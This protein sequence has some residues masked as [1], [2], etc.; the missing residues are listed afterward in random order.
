VASSSRPGLGTET[1]QQL[2]ALQRQVGERSTPLRVR[3]RQRSRQH[4]RRLML[5][6]VAVLVPLVLAL[7]LALDT[8][9]GRSWLGDRWGDLSRSTTVQEEPAG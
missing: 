7:G 4:A 8:G 2:T 1:L 3:E 5:R 9:G 6:L